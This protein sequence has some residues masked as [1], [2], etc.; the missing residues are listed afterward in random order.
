LDSNT[1]TASSP[2]GEPADLS[3]TAAAFAGGAGPAAGPSAPPAG[4]DRAHRSRPC[5]LV[6]ADE[7]EV[8]HSVHDLLRIDYHVLTCATGARALDLLRSDEEVHV[9][10]SDQRMPEM[11]GVDLLRQAKALRPATTRLLFTAHADIRAVIDA[12]NHGHVFRYLAKPWDPE[13]LEAVVRQAVDHHNLIV[14]KNR[15]LAELQTANA[16]LT[17]ANRLKGAFIQVASHELNT[18]VSVVLGMI[19]LWKISLGPE[20]SASDRHWVDRIGAAAQRLA[21]TVDRM[22]KL[23]RS[24]E[25]GRSLERQMFAVEPLLRNT[26]DELAPYLVLRRQSVELAV[27]PALAPI[28]ADRDKLS[29]AM[30]NLLANAI[31]FTPDGG[32]IRIGAGDEPGMPGWLRVRVSDEG[33]GIPAA[34]QHYLFEPFFTSFDTLRHSSGDYQYGKR[35]IGLGLWLV[36]TFV[37]LHGGRVEVAST[38]GQGSTF[39]LLL[40]RS[41]ADASEL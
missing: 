37:E 41:P 14:E 33:A 26:I 19:E 31:K 29:D 24:G 27:E 25:F 12:I 22:L 40:P 39:S 23:V 30:V 4:D 10:M 1:P 36:K 2:I 8:L 18:P 34:D 32:T 3:A 38:P 17:E 11:T 7:P 20:V 21:R 15:L 5:V 16:K 28:D 9:I 13:E 6:V 35:G